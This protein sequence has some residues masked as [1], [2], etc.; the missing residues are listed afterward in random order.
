METR[1][2]ILLVAIVGGLLIAGLLAF[3]YYLGVG[4]GSY[5][6]RYEIRFSKSVS[7]LTKGAPV[8]MQGVTVGRVESIELNPQ[9]PGST[10]VIVAVNEN[11]P[12][13]SGVRAD[14]SRAFM[15]G[16]ASIMLL[17][18]R[19]GPRIISDGNEL[20]RIEAVGG[21]R[22]RDPAAEAMAITGK[23]DKAVESL[24]AEGQAKISQGIAR[25]VD[26]TA[27]WEKAVSR[28]FDGF[29]KQKIESA[30]RGMSDASEMAER[31]NRSMQRA[32]DDIAKVRG[33]IRDFG[34]GAD[35]FADAMADARPGVQATSE[36]L[37]KS[38]KAV[39]RVR[40]TVEDLKDKVE[41]KVER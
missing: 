5:D 27:G 7:G 31:L 4:T 12:L 25:T 10:R 24:D 19:E 40:R 16:S 17:P 13:Y 37:K 33:D 26:Q 29:P 22:N 36:K 14:I 35:G 28:F 15:D 38:D 30:A 1:S 18:S 8:A 20:A 41:P 3:T 21:G 9:D 23:L 6:A 34:D 11:L 2:N 39:R 32:D